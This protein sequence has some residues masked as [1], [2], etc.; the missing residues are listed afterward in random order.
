MKDTDLTPRERAGY[1][2]GE[3]AG[4]ELAE[5][6]DRLEADDVLGRLVAITLF[7]FGENKDDWSVAFN[8][9]GFITALVADG[10]LF[11]GGISVHVW[12]NDHPPPHVH[13]LKKSE[14]DHEYIK[15][16]LETAEIDGDLPPWA[17][18]KQVKK[19]KALVRRHHGL[20]AGWW[21]KNHGDV[22]T[23]LA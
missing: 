19:M 23:L 21:E 15:I 10:K 13:I 1:N 11:D 16:N 22:V 4:W 8:D 7:E 12:P 3:P 18:S 17:N 9:D 5:S 14:P 2:L 20:F 6:E